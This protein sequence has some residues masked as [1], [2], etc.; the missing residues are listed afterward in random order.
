MAKN[1]VFRYGDHISLP[2]PTGTISG[3]PVKVGQLVGVAQVDRATVPTGTN[4]GGG[5]AEGSSS[6][7][8]NGAHKLK[9]DGAVTAI[10]TP[11]Y[12]QGDGTTR[13]DTLTTTVG[14]NTL[15]GYA[16]ETKTAAIAPI[17]VVI[18]RV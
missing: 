16:L 18:A 6:I 13:N 5:N 8:R 1:E 7:W 3:D 9:V 15:F 4:P 10:G 14:T 2:V 12:F 17:T 11:V